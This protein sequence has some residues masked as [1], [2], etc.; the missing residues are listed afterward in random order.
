MHSWGVKRTLAEKELEI[1]DP[2][3]RFYPPSAATKLDEWGALQKHREEMTRIQVEQER[4]AKEQQKQQFGAS[5]TKEIENKAKIRALEAVA[6]KAQER[7]MADQ[8]KL[9]QDLME[10]HTKNMERQK[11][12]ILSNDYSKT[13]AALEH[14]KMMERQQDLYNGMMANERARR[15]EEMFQQAEREKKEMIKGILSSGYGQQSVKDS[16]IDLNALDQ[17]EKINISKRLEMDNKI[18]EFNNRTGKSYAQFTHN[19][20]SPA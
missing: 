11:Q 8:K 12:N 4:M 16:K 14:K 18:R 5:L 1:N 19:V 6:G 2:N 17:A 7:E 15:E 10:E 20:L 13:M 9:E 3:K